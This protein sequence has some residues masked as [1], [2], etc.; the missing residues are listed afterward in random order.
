MPGFI[1]KTTPNLSFCQFAW[2][3]VVAARR[4]RNTDVV[5]WT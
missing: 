3:T 2:S 5:D 1:L 4:P